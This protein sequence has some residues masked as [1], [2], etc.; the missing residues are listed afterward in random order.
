[1]PVASRKSHKATAK[2]ERKATP[3]PL[4][5]STQWHR[6]H[7]RQTRQDK[8]IKQQLLT[9]HEEQAIVDFV[10]RADR[11]GY[12]ARVK[13]LRRYAAIL[14]RRRAPQRQGRT[15]SEVPAHSQT[16]NKDWP[17][18]FCKRHPELKVA[19]LRALDWRRH[20]KNIYAKTVNWFDLMRVQL[21]ETGVMQEICT[22]WT[23]LV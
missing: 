4:P 18:A 15:P 6:D 2:S 13:D 16:P 1:M 8:A 17:Q 23:R 9:P 20:E 11:N 5:P 19:R 7:G 12:P 21:E 3:P 22:T 14:L 10:L